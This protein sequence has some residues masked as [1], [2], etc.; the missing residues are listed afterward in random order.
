[1]IKLIQATQVSEL[2]KDTNN[3]YKV[4][5]VA[6]DNL[7]DNDIFKY[8]CNLYPELHEA[9][10]N[11]PHKE[12]VVG[13]Y[14]KLVMNNGDNVYVAIIKKVDKYQAYL[15]DVTKVLSNIMDTIPEGGGVII[16]NITKET[17]KLH[18]AIMIPTIIDHIERNGITIYFTITDSTFTDIVE[19]ISDDGIIWK[20]DSWKSDWMLHDDDIVFVEILHELN[21][22]LHGFKLSKSKLIKCYKV[23]YDAGMFPKFEFY[24]TDYGE[25]FKMFM[26]KYSSL[27]NHGLLMNTQHY[28]KVVEGVPARTD[29]RKIGRAHV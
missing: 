24:T 4:I 22:M 26:P 10:T 28:A 25:Y 27:L 18:E 13:E 21:H 2:Y 3:K 14:I 20:Q 29:L 1:M 8:H 11:L 12:Y 17:T 9:F 5:P 15:F 6:L 16:P 7:T 19:S 23:C